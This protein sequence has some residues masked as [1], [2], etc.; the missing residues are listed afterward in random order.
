M[1]QTDLQAQLYNEA[2]YQQLNKQQTT[3]MLYAQ[4]QARYIKVYTIYFDTSG[5]ATRG[6]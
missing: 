6:L 4:Q 1:K 3:N 2:F 5:Y